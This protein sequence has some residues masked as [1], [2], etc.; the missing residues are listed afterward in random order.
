MKKL[1]RIAV[2]ALGLTLAISSIGAQEEAS[3]DLDLSDHVGV[4]EALLEALIDA[5]GFSETTNAILDD[6]SESGDPLYIAPLVDLGFFVRGVATPITDALGQVSGQDFGSDWQAYFEWASANDIALPEGYA[7]FKGALFARLV[8]PAFTR[9]FEAGVEDGA[10]ANMLEAVWGGVR[11]DGIPSLVNAKQISPDDASEEGSRFQNFCN[12]GDCSYPAADEFV[13]G[14]YIDGDARAYPLRQ[15]NWHEMFNDVIGQAPLYDAPDGEIV[16]HFRAPTD[17]IAVA[18]QGVGWVQIFGE[19][20]GCPDSGWLAEPEAL[21]WLGRVDGWYETS[22]NLPD[23]AEESAEPLARREGFRGRVDGTPVMLSY[24]TLCGSGI[25]YNPTLTNV[26]IDGELLDETTL[27]FGSTGL[28]MRSNKLMYDRTTNT[29]WNSMLGTPA[30][31]ELA[32]Q[33]IELER[34]PVV[35]TDWASW[36]EEHPETSVLSLNTGYNRN[37]QNGGAYEDYFNNPDFLM[38]P[39]WQQDTSEQ[40][41]KE[42]VFALNLNDTPKAYPLRTI[43]PELVV[44]D[45]LAGVNVT[46]ISHES[47][48]R[49]F[50]EPGGASVR[51]YARSDFEFTAGD[52]RREVLDETGAVWEVTEDALVGPDGATLERLPG[53]LAFWFGWFSYY[54]DTL[55][56][57]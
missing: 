30:W 32:G 50:F 22:M 20:A 47:P 12:N 13:F 29:V 35:V 21:E 49:D 36:L 24:C 8:D 31:G 1:V 18:R 44:N 42:M 19:S 17:F 43:V 28:L 52:N 41:N 45:T 48:G 51:A 15:L 23:L 46:L 9:F 53:H 26:E 10:Q 4:S 37:Y 14:V 11:V 39:V 16:C 57:E 38:F 33:D 27:E 40:Q 55:V 7:G 34:L 2:L 25:L 3:R 54:P 56:F 6:I 5:R